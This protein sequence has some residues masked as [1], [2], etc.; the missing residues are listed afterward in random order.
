MARSG[1]EA[2]RRAG[3]ARLRSWVA[4]GMLI[5]VSCLASRWRVDESELVADATRGLPPLLNVQGVPH[6]PAELAQGPMRDILAVGERYC[7]SC[8]RLSD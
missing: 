7:M 2:A 6:C 5:P 3:A 8:R 1:L 4:E